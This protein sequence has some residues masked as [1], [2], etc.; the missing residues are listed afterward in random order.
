MKLFKLNAEYDVEPEKDT[1]MLI[2]EFAELWKLKY[3]RSERDHDGRKRYRGLSEIVFLYFFCDY[4]SEFSE[5]TVSERKEAALNGAGLDSSYKISG[6]LKGAQQKYLEMQET[7]ELKL[8]KSAY[9]T[10]AKLQSYFDEIIIDDKNAKN[11]LDNLAKLGN[12]LTGLKKL[13]E[14]VRKQEQKDGG[15]RGSAEKGFLDN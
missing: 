8:L 1:I 9:G 11:T 4:R 13:E 5:L 3:N 14:Q 2:P 10:I 15:T 6:T 7:R 12:V